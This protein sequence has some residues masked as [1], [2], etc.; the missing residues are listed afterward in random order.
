MDRVV[1]A[2]RNNSGVRLPNLPPKPTGEGGGGKGKG[3]QIPM[4]GTEGMVTRSEYDANRRSN[5]LDSLKQKEAILKEKN[6]L[7]R[8]LKKGNN[9]TK[10]AKAED[11]AKLARA[12]VAKTKRNIRDIKRGKRWGK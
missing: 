2:F 4:P 12:D 9:L 3:G 6:A 11:A 10:L 1:K 8:E 5:I 7:V